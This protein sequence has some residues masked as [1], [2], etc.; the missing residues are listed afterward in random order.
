MKTN[1]KSFAT[2]LAMGLLAVGARANVVLQDNFDS[3]GTGDLVSVSG[4]LWSSHSG[5]TPMNVVADASVSAPN[6][7]Q[8]TRFNS[9][10]D[11]ATLANAPYYRA[12][13]NAVGDSVTALYFKFTLRMSSADMPTAAGTYFAHFKDTTTS[14]FRARTY[15][16]TGGA[17]AGFYRVGIGNSTGTPVY[18]G[19]D[20]APDTTYVIVVRYNVT[21]GE[22]TL[23]VNPSSESDTSI[24]GTDTPS[25]L[26]ISTM[27]FRQA[28]GEGTLNV[29]DLVV[30]TTFNDVLSGRPLV[31]Q[32]P[33]DNVSFVGQAVSFSTAVFGAQP[34]AYQWYYNTNT[35][36]TD[37]TSVIGATSNVLVLS[38]L[39]IGASGTYSCT[40]TNTAGTALTRYASL[41]VYS[42]PLNP[43]ITNQPAAGSTNFVGDDV[44]F[45]VVAGGVPE[46]A[47]QWKVIA[48]GVTNNVTGANVSGANS[49][50]LTLTG[51]MTNQTGVYF[52]TITNILGSTNS[53]LATLLVKPSPVLN[54]A[55][56]RTMVDP[57]TL[58]PTNT[59]S[60]YIAQGIVTSWTNMTGSAS[61]E[62]YM[63]DNT[64]GIVVFWA[65]APSPA[66]LPPAGA[67]VRVTG[68]MASFNGLVEL[69]ASFTDPQTSVQIISTNNPL[70]APQPLPFD[71]NVV[72]NP[73]TMEKLEG[74]YFVASNVTLTAGATFVGGVNEAITNNAHHVRSD[75]LLG[76]NYT[77]EVGQT[78]TLYVNYYTD[79]PNQPKYT[80]PVTIYGVLGNYKGLY[81]FT[82]TRYA[83][84]ISYIH[85]TNVV[86]HVVRPGDL[87]TNNYLENFLLPAETLTVHESIGDPE[88][89]SVT[90]TPVAA[91]L[92]ASA[93]WSDITGGP[94][95]TA[96]FH[97]T[98][99]AADSGS[100]YVV[101]LAVAS[102]GGAIFTNSFTVYVPDTNEQRIAIS[103]FLANPTTDTGAPNFNPLNRATDTVGVSTNDEFIEIANQSGNDEYLLGWGI[104]NG[105]TRVEDFSLFGP[106]LSSSNAI[107]V[108]GGNPG[109]APNL[110]VYKEQATYSGGLLLS[111]SGGTLTLRNANG[112]IV[113]RV[114]YA[115]GDLSTNGSLTRFPD[116]INGP[117]VPQSYVSAYRNTPGLQYDGSAWSQPFKV[118][119]GVNNVGIS[120]INGQVLF[121]FT[122]NPAQANTLWGADSVTGPFK[123]LY[124]RQFP[125]ASGAFSNA[126]SAPIQFYYITTQ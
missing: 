125:G 59:T 111:A 110:P 98:P 95:G 45:S 38:N 21:T 48:N 19:T 67:L 15:V 84:I 70:P 2:L 89:G 121:N 29:D 22:A 117:F 10:D 94:T 28:S 17:A 54:V 52:V 7:L 72:N 80:G 50:T 26:D 109:E 113:D 27:A 79:L 103:E 49:D 77:N 16:A 1:L 33:Q 8:V 23:W 41:E 63:Q 13:T 76:L 74:T 37:S 81:E 56:L 86:S 61:C 104:F 14:G 18:W 39:T 47:Y 11:N 118:P 25:L 108:Y 91:G 31:V 3:Y 57:I 64:A 114:A 88:G 68:R 71:P 75:S 58:V 5:T 9:Q 90:L 55:A 115:A 62:F 119:A 107:V 83:D 51:V 34:L 40:V 120:V 85:Q 44:A 65:G 53:S 124:G 12:G 78:F 92:P 69:E 122:A 60:I 93:S 20:M 42:A 87:L 24:T 6:A 101:S 30:G 126:I 4:G 99:V 97:F 112:N 96:V 100:N 102:A 66:N 116:N 43:T 46:P 106:T 73:A 36:L 35:P 82:P 105:T 32:E 123:V